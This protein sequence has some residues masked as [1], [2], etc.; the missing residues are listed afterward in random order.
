MQRKRIVIQLAGDY[1]ENPSK[2]S[3]PVLG[4][5]MTLLCC[6]PGTWEG[7]LSGLHFADLGWNLE[8]C[9]QTLS[10][11]PQSS[12]LLHVVPLETDQTRCIVF[13]NVNKSK[14]RHWARGTKWFTVRHSVTRSLFGAPSV[15]SV[16]IKLWSA[17]S[18]NNSKWRTNSSERCLQ[19]TW[20]LYYSLTILQAKTLKD[21]ATVLNLKEYGIFVQL[22]FTVV[23]ATIPD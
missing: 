16:W 18:R 11:F 14:S 13:L 4:L 19:T 5:I 2:F 20:K 1:S 17:V 7:L 10:P 22:H 21:L 8:K 15:H 9:W 23:L 12:F 3:L 6:E